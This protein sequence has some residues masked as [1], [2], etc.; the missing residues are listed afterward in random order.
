M[1]R[2]IRIAA[3]FVRDPGADRGLGGGVRGVVRSATRVAVLT[4]SSSLASLA[5]VRLA[6]PERRAQ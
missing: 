1:R 5:R 3:R 4:D 6:P 2:A